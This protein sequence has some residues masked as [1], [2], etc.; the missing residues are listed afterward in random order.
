MSHPALPGACN[1][2]GASQSAFAWY[3]DFQAANAQCDAE[4]TACLL[5]GSTQ[6]CTSVCMD[7]ADELSQSCSG[8]AGTYC[9]IAGSSTGTADHPPFQFKSATCVPT[10]CDAGYNGAVQAW[11][12]GEACGAA[13]VAGY[14]NLAVTC[15]Y[16]LK[17]DSVW[18]VVGISVASVIGLFALCC[19]AYCGLRRRWCPC[20]CPRRLEDADDEEE[21]AGGDGWGD[22]SG[23]A[24]L[25]QEGEEDDDDGPDDPVLRMQR[26][27]LREERGGAS[28]NTGGGPPGA[29]DP[30]GALAGRYT[31]V[32]MPPAQ[33]GA[34]RP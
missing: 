29:G 9:N 26:Q 34:G 8:S 18:E 19:L 14:C 28:L 31:M 30:L 11:A 21:A 1:I 25:L 15:A 7:L 23:S 20:L 2:S 4:F 24:Q 3:Y 27:L 33:S 22:G 5:S 6:M 12:E 16:P 32:D 17:T 10:R 13:N